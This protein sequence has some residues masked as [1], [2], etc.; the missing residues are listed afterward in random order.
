MYL[1]L[2][3]QLL[4]KAGLLLILYCYIR[5]GICLV[6][7]NVFRN[8]GRAGVETFV[9]RFFYVISEGNKRHQKRLP[10][11]EIILKKHDKFLS[12]FPFNLE[13]KYVK[14]LYFYAFLPSLLVASFVICGFWGCHMW[15]MSRSLVAFDTLIC[16]KWEHQSITLT[17][18]KHRFRLSKRCKE[19]G[20]LW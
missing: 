12:A 2:Y 14:N 13:K 17:T 8:N 10:P 18:Q 3:C 9:L 16:H 11:Y 6:T 5:A 4:V 15:Q 20:T 1:N 7:K 19:N